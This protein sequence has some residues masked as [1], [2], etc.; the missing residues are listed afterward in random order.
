MRRAKLRL[1]LEIPERDH[2]A[3]R[4]GKL[5]GAVVELHPFLLVEVEHRYVR[6][7]G[8]SEE[9]PVF[10]ECD[11]VAVGVVVS[12]PGG[13]GLHDHLA[14]RR[15]QVPEPD[16]AVGARRDQ[17]RRVG[18]EFETQAVGLCSSQQPE[19]EATVGGPQPGGTIRLTRR[20]VIPV[21]S[22]VYL[23]DRGIPTAVNA[24]SRSGAQ[25][26][27]SQLTIHSAGKQH[28]ARFAKLK[29][30]H[31]TI[32][33]VQNAL[34]GTGTI[35]LLG[36]VGGRALAVHHPGHNAV[37][38][39]LRNATR[40]DALAQNWRHV[41][42]GIR[43]LRS[44]QVPQQYPAVIQTQCGEPAVER[45]NGAAGAPEHVLERVAEQHGPSFGHPA[46]P[47]AVQ[48][49]PQRQ[50]VVGALLGERHQLIGVLHDGALTS[51][52]VHNLPAVLQLHLLGEQLAGEPQRQIRELRFDQQLCAFGLVQPELVVEVP[53]VQ[54]VERS[55]ELVRR[56]GIDPVFC[57][58]V[59]PEQVT[60]AVV[61]RLPVEELHALLDD[62]VQEGPLMVVQPADNDSP[63]P[64][65][66]NQVVLL[67]QEDALPDQRRAGQLVGEHE[68]QQLL[69]E[70]AELRLEHE[71]EHLEEV[72]T[73]LRV[74]RLNP[75]YLF[76]PTCGRAS[77]ISR[78]TPRSTHPA[79][80][81]ASG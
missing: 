70:V 71:R 44:N 61:E 57:D 43:A 55:L 76:P 48:E 27:Q 19:R 64:F 81:P 13:G 74:S 59:P 26:P 45:G 10:G 8:G 65:R 28:L 3:V 40:G 77:R 24:P 7:V 41:L 5:R 18:V 31:R 20:E 9:T 67:L 68:F 72:A 17:H 54:P 2:A 23:H 51:D 22:V 42:Y 75:A 21:W 36:A 60:L 69:D 14:S 50:V 6:A 49:S 62:L 58:K 79:A 80:H 35:L 29:A 56:G 39:A 16:V 4:D 32:M 33:P 25:D 11:C 78:G 12:E 15:A 66:E 53:D 30:L 37:A 63:G 1:T 73:W 47:L 52:G 46:L 38:G 34:A